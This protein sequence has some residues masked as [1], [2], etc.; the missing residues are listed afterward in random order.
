MSVNLC[1]AGFDDG[2][3]L[4]SF[5]WDATEDPYKT[6]TRCLLND[7]RVLSGVCSPELV[8]VMRVELLSI[9]KKV[10]PR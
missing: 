8:N 3:E 6:V 5:S 2:A 1:V 9:L 7:L 4:S 10:D